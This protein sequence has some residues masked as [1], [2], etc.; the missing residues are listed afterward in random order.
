MTEA[1]QA[2][3]PVLI[4]APPASGK[5]Y[6]AV[7]LAVQ[8]YKILYLAGRTDL[9]AQAKDEV[10]DLKQQEGIII[11]QQRQFLARIDIV[12]HSRATTLE[13]LKK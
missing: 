3:E 13:I 6:N 11:L 9:Y 8:G 10:E 5:T 12:K 2:D 7:R 4:E 1:C